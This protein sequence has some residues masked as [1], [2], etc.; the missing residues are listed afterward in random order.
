MGGGKYKDVVL[1]GR[2]FSHKGLKG[3]DEVPRKVLAY[4]EK[5]APRYLEMAPGWDA[6]RTDRLDTWMAFAQDV[7]PERVSYPWT[8]RELPAGLAPPTGLGAR[9]Y[10]G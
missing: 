2:M 5:H 6:P 9:V 7:P 4:I 3:Y 1:L 8:K 10:R